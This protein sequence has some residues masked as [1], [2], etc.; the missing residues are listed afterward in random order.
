M[1]NSLANMD[2]DFIQQQQQQTRNPQKDTL[3]QTEIIK[4]YN[5]C[6]ANSLDKGTSELEE[7]QMS[8]RRPFPQHLCICA[9]VALGSLKLHC[10]YSLPV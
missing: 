6:I 5:G 3:I 1:G 9:S 10:L 7:I 2:Q 4:R 8:F